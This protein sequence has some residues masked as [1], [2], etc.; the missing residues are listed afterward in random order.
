[1]WVT[2][3]ATAMAAS[4][5]LSVVSLTS[6]LTKIRDARHQFTIENSAQTRQAVLHRSS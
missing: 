4:I 6:Q 1:M 2:V 5:C 3:I